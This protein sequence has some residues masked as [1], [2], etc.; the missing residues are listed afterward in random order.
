MYLNLIMSGVSWRSRFTIPEPTNTPTSTRTKWNQHCKGR[1]AFSSSMDNFIG[2]AQSSSANKGGWPRWGQGVFNRGWAPS[3]TNRS[4]FR[5][6]SA[7][8]VLE[9][10]HL[11]R[12]LGRTTRSGTLETPIYTNLADSLIV[13]E[14]HTSSPGRFVHVIT[15]NVLIHFVCHELNVCYEKIIHKIVIALQ[16]VSSALVSINVDL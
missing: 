15:N 16:N 14:L 11:R 6:I 12:I 3:Y 10:S 2:Q 7:T 8:G 1:V 5:T 4:S 9:H 13:G